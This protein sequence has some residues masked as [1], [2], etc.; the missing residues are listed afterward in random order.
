MPDKLFEAIDR[1]KLPLGLSFVGLVLITGGIF[2]SNLNK[3]VKTESFPKES[4][5]ESKK[6]LS[7]DVS[8]AVKNPGVYQ[9]SDGSRIEQA[10]EKAGGFAD[11]ANKE[12]VS[13]ILN[14]AQKLN[15]GSKIYIPTEGETASTEQA[16]AEV[17][18][19]SV[20]K[21]SQ[22]NINTA[23]QV[24]LEALPGIGPVSASR[25]ISERPYQKT[26]DLIDKK[27]IGKAVYEKIKNSLVVY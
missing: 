7:V 22:I 4:L 16:G 18:V 12:Y 20:S 25:I 24:E 3:K 26:E 8:G 17:N 15:D 2:A 5:V 10:I 9:L 27:I 19:A 1:F 6:Q 11:N 13:K 21:Y 23:A 14:L